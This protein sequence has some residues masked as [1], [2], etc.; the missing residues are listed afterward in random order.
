MNP[1]LRRNLWLELSAHRVIAMPVVL[2][3]LM[4]LISARASDPWG[5]VFTI[6]L[7]SFVLL[8]HLWGA[9]NASDAVTE[10]VRARTWDWQRLS[11]LGA[12]QMTWGKLVG[13]T[14]LGWYGAAWCLA[15]MAFAQLW[16][17]SRSGFGWIALG[18]VASGLAVQGAALAGSVQA[19]RKDMRA[20]VRLG[21]LALVGAA[22]VSAFGIRGP[23]NVASAA[24]WFAR[25]YES[26]PFL[27]LSAVAFAAWG[28]LAAYREMA[29]EL[30]ERALPWA[31]PAFGIFLGAYLAGFV[32]ADTPGYVRMVV[33][34]TFLVAVVLV[35]FGLFVDATTAMTLR[36]VVLHARS[37]DWRRTLESLPYWATALALAAVFAIATAL[38]PAPAGDL[39]SPRVREWPGAYPAFVLLLGAVR[40][41]GL[42][43]F[44]AL[45]A[46]PRRVEATALLYIVLAWWIVPGL[47]DVFGLHALSQAVRPIGLAGW[48]GTLVMATQAAIVWAGV[49]W[50]WRRR[51]FALDGPPAS[52]AAR[53]V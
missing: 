22:V 13:A 19:A 16:F 4:G 1:E 48:L 23:W 6:A 7:W 8:V 40:D 14:A 53:G 29:R 46:R 18:L 49:A 45:A 9:R 10:E 34:F 35:Y 47:L 32:H 26:G 15:A 37:G 2:L 24:E 25:S 50:R 42:L 30:K 51:E 52:G 31:Y 17:A 12:W 39:V 28:V 36:R 41:A 20:G 33:L 11:S 27:A 3:L 21:V 43:A 5:P 38:L 44:F